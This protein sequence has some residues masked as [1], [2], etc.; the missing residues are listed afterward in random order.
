M[1]Q[2][3]AWQPGAG[4]PAGRRRTATSGQAARSNGCIGSSGPTDRGR[5]R[6]GG[7]SQT[8]LNEA[9]IFGGI[10]PIGSEATPKGQLAKAGDFGQWLSLQ[11]RHY[12]VLSRI[13][14]GHKHER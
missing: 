9:G 14:D 8:R 6:I 7:G 2:V 5:A 1:G 3:S 4:S 10:E 11:I 13:A 12:A